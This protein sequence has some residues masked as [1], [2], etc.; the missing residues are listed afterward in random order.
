MSLRIAMI[1]DHASPLGL[2]GGV[3][4]GGQ[5]VYV[6][7]LAR[8]LVR[9]G[10]EVDIFTRRDCP[11]LP[12]IVPWEGCRVI[13]VPAGPP[14]FVPKERLLS[15]MSDF[16]GVF[17]RQ[18]A[19]S[20]RPYDIAHAHF[21]MSGLVALE[22]K[23]RLRLPFV[24]TFHA[25]GRVRRL[26]QGSADEFSDERFAWEDQIVR[27]ADRILAAC[28]QDREDLIELYA[29]DPEKISMV[30]CGFDPDEFWPMKRLE[31]RAR[32]G[33]APEE[34]VILQLGRMVPRKGVDT[35]IQG[36]SQF[37]RARKVGA[38]LMVVG[39]E[40]DD[41]E[42]DRSPELTRLRRLTR[43][44]AVE[45]RVKFVGRRRR[46]EL[47]DY[48]CAANVF[49]T[50]PWYEPFGI[51]PLEAMACGT[52]VVGSKVGGIKYTVLD[53]V[54]GLLIP[55]KNPLALCDAL[56][57]FAEDPVLLERCRR[58]SVRR[59]HEGFSWRQVALSV[60]EAYRQVL[61]TTRSVA[62]EAVAVNIRNEDSQCRA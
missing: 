21:W 4:S 33:L 29:A 15:C 24:M 50:L 61:N 60:E 57:R 40:H 46:A 25:L 14:E 27:E 35:V 23:R 38:K 43:S 36:F 31:A 32:V 47:R 5:N 39:G 9:H 30:P 56:T 51:T 2:P 58:E 41:P 12:D 18:L 19:A 48:Y 7:Q 20:G 54:T 45:H 49:A 13:H 28:P 37:V 10:N 26:H 16:T 8:H 59:V 3:D 11:Q 52:P 55:P 42:Q 44:L 34:F 62:S 17:M 53:G 1:S 22:A 6:A